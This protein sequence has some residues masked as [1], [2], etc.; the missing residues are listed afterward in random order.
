MGPR[1]RVGTA[2]LQ[3]D[4]SRLAAA[5]LIQRGAAFSLSW[6]IGSDDPHS[7]VRAAPVHYFREVGSD[8]IAGRT[9]HR[10]ARP[11]FDYNDDFIAMPLQTS[12]QWDGLAHVSMHETM[13][14]GFWLGTVTALGSE[15]LSVDRW[16]TNFIGR[17]ELVSRVVSS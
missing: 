15:E 13:Y 5:G 12:T 1:R 10:M 3:D 17:G 7:V 11:D 6:S 14:N 8:H 9:A 4:S 16:A 2:N